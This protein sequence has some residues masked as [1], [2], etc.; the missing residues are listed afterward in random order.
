MSLSEGTMRAVRFHAYG[1]PEQ[2][3]VEE[4]ARPAPRQGQ[5]L[6]RV[7]AVGVNPVD[8]KVRKGDLQAFMPVPLP[9]TPGNEFAG[10]V[11]AVGPDVTGVAVGQRVFGRASNTYAEYALAVADQLAQI[12]DALS[13]EQA[14]TIP[15]GG[16]TAWV[17][18]FEAGEL[19]AG[20][21]LL[22]LGAAGGV[23]SYATQFGRWKGAHVIG[24]ASAANLDY[25]RSLG[26]EHAIDY[27]TT[28]LEQAVQDVDIVLDTVGG[29]AQEQ[30]FHVLKP[31]GILIAIATMAPVEQ[32][33]AHGVRTA[34]VQLTSGGYLRQIADLVA[35]GT[36]MAP[37]GEIYT[38]AQAG[39][40]H[41][42]SETG[43]GRG[44]ILLRTQE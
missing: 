13:C 30:A 26:A 18:L 14:A 24:T 29:A 1:S 17:G 39:A 36:I 8:W 35:S 3:A 33:A 12:P 20:Q 9:H 5:V 7:H 19:Q 42:R 21:R 22:I 44:R 41:A 2:L 4:V 32:A 11:A 10:V 16:G 37:V 40:A 6:V 27:T 31:G 25:V 43:R 23:G 34:R 28:P 15:I 38:L